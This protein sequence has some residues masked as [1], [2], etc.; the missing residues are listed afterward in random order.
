MTRSPVIMAEKIA[1]YCEDTDMRVIRSLLVM[2][3]FALATLTLAQTEGASLDERGYGLYIPSTYD[4][5]GEDDL[6]L[7]IV[8]H[9]FGDTWQNF[10]R[11]TGFINRAEQDNFIVAFPQGY[12]RQWNDGSVGDHYEDDVQLLSDLIERVDRDYRVDRDRIYLAGFSNGGT[13]TFQAACERP[14]LF[15]GIASVGGTMRN[16]IAIEEVGLC[17]D[18]QMP[19]LIIHGTQD[20]VVPFIGGEF[21]YGAVV[22]AAY[23]RQNN[24]CMDEDVPTYDPDNF[25][26]GFQTFLFDECAGGNLTMLHVIENGAHVWFGAESYVQEQTP[27]QP[28]LDTARLIWGFFEA[29][30]AA[31][32]AAES[33][34]EATPEATESSD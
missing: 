17:A 12:L 20:T 11:A 34:P 19:V 23:W 3:I 24:E 31:Q 14:D 8:L 29:S 6:P 10:H 9:G 13:M 7:L 5:E 21:R 18:V 32:Q 1:I 15:A 2:C 22:G 33:E 30:Y 27:Q 16:G 28:G 25:R 26:N 4:E